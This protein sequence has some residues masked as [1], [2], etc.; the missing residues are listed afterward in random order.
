[1]KSM[2]PFYFIVLFYFYF[3]LNI[4]LTKTD[5]YGSVHVFGL[6]AEHAR[7]ASVHINSLVVLEVFL[8]V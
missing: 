5:I 3:Y 4:H 7:S 6:F 8:I 1:M 2:F